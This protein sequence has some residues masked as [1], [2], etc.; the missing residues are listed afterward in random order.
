M[1]IV[2]PDLDLVYEEGTL[3]RVFR[4]PRATIR[5]WIAT[6]HLPARQ[7]PDGRAVVLREEL[8]QMLRNLPRPPQHERRTP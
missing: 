4:R 8:L 1:A 6:G 7:L 3:A 2:A 5:E